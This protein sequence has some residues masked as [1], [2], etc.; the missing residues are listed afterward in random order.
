MR[1]HD[2]TIGPRSQQTDLCCSHEQAY[3][4]I[5]KFPTK[6]ITER[7]QTEDDLIWKVL[8]ALGWTAFLRQQNSRAAGR[9]DVPDGLLFSDDAAKGGGQKAAEEWRRYEFGLAVVE[10]KRWTSSARSPIRPTR[11]RNRPVD[12]DAALFAPRGRPHDRQ[13]PLGYA[14]Q[15]RAVAALLPRRTFGFR[16]VLRAGPRASCLRSPAMTA[17]CSPC[18]RRIAGTGCGSL[19]SFFSRTAFLPDAERS[20]HLPSARD[21]RGQ[22]LRRARRRKSLQLVFGTVFPSLPRRS[23]PLRRPRH[24]RK[25]GKRP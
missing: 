13:T 22:I 25:S 2:Y 5:E 15:W 11:R 17:A 18:R 3:G 9:E 7:G 14:D 24:C 23:P 20:A 1:L 10:S 21:R 19:P 8:S 4:N 12:P 16:A 6:P